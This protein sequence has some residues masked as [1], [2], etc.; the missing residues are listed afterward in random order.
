MLGSRPRDGE[1]GF[2][3][4]ELMV[5][6]LIIAILLAV[7]IPSFVGAQER[8]RDRA[9]QSDLRN[10]LTAAKVLAVDD[11]GQ[12]TGVTEA[13]L[14]TAGTALTFAAVASA[15]VVGVESSSDAVYLYTASAAGSYFGIATNR[16]G[17]IGFCRFD[18]GAD[19]A[20][21]AIDLALSGCA[22]PRW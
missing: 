6:V 17:A 19:A 10:A 16:A 3:L 20:A 15:G 13:T 2:T 11:G 21:V 5:V 18:D 4:L 7:A 1:A 12:L 14:A 9:A 22:E 8:A